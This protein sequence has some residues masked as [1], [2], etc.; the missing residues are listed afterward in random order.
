MNFKDARKSVNVQD[1]RVHPAISEDYYNDFMQFYD[2]SEQYS[3]GEK[4]LNPL[5]ILFGDTSGEYNNVTATMRDV[6][7][8]MNG[9]TPN[10]NAKSIQDYSVVVNKMLQKS[11]GVSSEEADRIISVVGIGNIA[12]EFDPGF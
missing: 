6:L 8:S 7:S 3:S 10:I 9:A 12:K 1:R 4:T 5:D 11:L 2:P